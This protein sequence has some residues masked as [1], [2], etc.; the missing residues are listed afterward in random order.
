MRTTFLAIALV[1]C[2]TLAYAAEPQDKAACIDAYEAGQPARA[3]GRLTEARERFLQCA[4]DP[5]PPAMREECTRWVVE[6]EAAIPT[7]VVV[8]R[9]GGRAIAGARVF[10][11]DREVPPRPTGTAISVDPGERR[12]RVERAPG[13]AID[14]TEI[15]HVGEKLRVVV[16]DF[17]TP[18]PI[19][20]R[21]KWPGYALLGL[22]AAGAVSF[23][24]FGVSGLVRYEHLKSTCSPGC[25]VADRDDVRTRFLVADISLGV[26]V[27]AF[28]GA[29]LWLLGREGPA[30]S[31]GETS[32]TVR[33]APV[34][35]G[36]RAVVG[37]AF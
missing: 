16:V 9:D 20:S 17:P 31:G 6:A 35:G 22:G 37:S 29:A 32:V 26:S 21:P 15:L 30:D 3:A 4:A 19:V 5:C 27:L 23:G 25:A 34:A 2:P 33:I 14:R 24:I 28:G 18:P 13:D 10:V 36:A 12:F 11:D 7:V 1:S 8:A